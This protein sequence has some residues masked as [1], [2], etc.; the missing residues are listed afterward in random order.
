MGSLSAGARARPDPLARQHGRAHPR[1]G[2][3]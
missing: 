3:G 2:Y 1:A